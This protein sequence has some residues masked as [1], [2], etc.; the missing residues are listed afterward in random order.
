VNVVENIWLAKASGLTI[1]FQTHSP[2]IFFK[3]AHVKSVKHTRI[4]KLNTRFSTLSIIVSYD[5][6]RKGRREGGR[7]W[8]AQPHHRVAIKRPFY[9]DRIERFT[10]WRRAYR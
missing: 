2:V 8:W 9:D 7:G 1:Y 4:I 3:D 5:G 6:I 10:V